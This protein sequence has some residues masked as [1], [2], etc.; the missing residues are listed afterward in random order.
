MAYDKVA[1]KLADAPCLTSLPGGKRHD[2][3]RLRKD[4]TQHTYRRD[5]QNYKSW[6]P[7]Y[8]MKIWV[9]F[10]FPTFVETS[11]S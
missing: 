5:T 3:A 8:H 2:Q 11:S 9:L 7:P 10:R 1:G 4:G 6:E